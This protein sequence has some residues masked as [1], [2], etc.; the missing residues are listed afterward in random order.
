LKV[1]AEL[2]RIESPA[3]I[4][5]GGK[6]VESSLRYLGCALGF[7]F[8]AIWMGVGFGPA[9]VCVLLAGLGYGAVFMAE[10]AQA[11]RPPNKAPETVGVPLVSEALRLDHEHDD[12]LSADATTPLAAEA[13]YGWPWPSNDDGQ[14]AK[15]DP[16]VV[17]RA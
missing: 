4:R 14:N 2:P 1:F 17:T 11:N 16:G 8:G 13:E 10:R 7:G 5:R 15:Q 12:S 3:R 6:T 9:I